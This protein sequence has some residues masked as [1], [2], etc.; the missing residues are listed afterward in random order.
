MALGFKGSEP[1]PTFFGGWADFQGRMDR[2]EDWRSEVATPL[3][4]HG[5]R[6]APNGALTMR[7][8]VRPITVFG[9]RIGVTKR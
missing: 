9:Q 7:H 3:G 8:A 4:K 5:D 6:V 1:S 2:E